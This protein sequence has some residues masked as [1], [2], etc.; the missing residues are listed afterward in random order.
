MKISA[1]LP[2][3]KQN[4]N[5][6]FFTSANN[7]KNTKAAVVFIEIPYDS[8]EKSDYYED[9]EILAGPY[10]HPF[11]GRPIINS[12]FENNYEKNLTFINWLLDPERKM[13]KRPKLLIEKIFSLG[14]SFDDDISEYHKQLTTEAYNTAKSLIGKNAPI[15]IPIGDINGDGVIDK[16]VSGINCAMI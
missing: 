9:D 3:T 1:N 5:K 13:Y 10:G 11:S 2:A 15:S 6:L 14:D 4:V 16:I 12:G 8:F 7:T